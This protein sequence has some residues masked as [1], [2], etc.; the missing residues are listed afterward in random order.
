M[1]SLRVAI[2]GYGLSGRC[3]HAPLIAATEGLE[4]AVVVI[5]NTERRAEA[6]REH[7]GVR[8]VDRYEEVAESLQL[9]KRAAKRKS[10]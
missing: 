1:T 10:A 6:E 5:S 4:V 9:T 7:P 3:F 8:V 2:V